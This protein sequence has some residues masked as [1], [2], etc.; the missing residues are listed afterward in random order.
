MLIF[1]PSCSMMLLVIMITNYLLAVLL[2]IISR[3]GILKSSLF[4]D[5]YTEER[6]PQIENSS[7]IDHM[8][9][10]I[11]FV[12]CNKRILQHRE[13]LF[14]FSVQS[15]IR[16]FGTINFPFERGK[17]E[18]IFN[19]KRILISYGKAGKAR[20]AKLPPP[21]KIE[22]VRAWNPLTAQMSITFTFSSVP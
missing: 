4:V 10:Y 15:T 7:R 9:L 1:C 12:L 16:L 21:I 22:I 18:V 8:L 20:N 19:I 13:K 11:L 6:S 5:L 14:W 2:I 17:N 3:N